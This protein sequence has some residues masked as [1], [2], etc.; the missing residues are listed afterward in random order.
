LFI[1]LTGTPIVIKPVYIILLTIF[2][3]HVL[4]KLYFIDKTNNKK[5]Y[6]VLVSDKL[7][8][9]LTYVEDKNIVE[10]L[11]QGP[12]D[13]TA[14]VEPE[15]E[16]PIPTPEP[17]PEPEPPKPS[18]GI[19]VDENGIKMLHP[20]T[21][22]FVEITEGKDHRNGQRY[23]KNHSFGNYMWIGYVKLGAGQDVMEHKTDG[24]NHGGCNEQEDAGKKFPVQDCCWVEVNISLTD[25][26]GYK[27][28]Q[29][30]ISS[31]HPH[32]K[33]Y[34]APK[35]SIGKKIFKIK[36]E[37][38]LG[39]AA[40]AWQEGEFRHLQG[41]VDTNPFDK[42]GKPLNNWEMGIDLVDT[43]FITTPDLAKRDVQHI[44]KTHV[45]DKNKGMVGLESEVRMNNA[46]N[47]DTEIKFARV[48]ELVHP[49][50][51]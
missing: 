5:Y 32:P 8:G 47:H 43:G 16:P 22:K 11:W 9:A 12:I 26:K 15:P 14:S 33:N 4:L 48:Y 3:L 38:W 46:T 29:F 23:S 25:R 37:Q 40:C 28:G 27:P 2:R 1:I 44:A 24:P 45:K 36:P 6:L 49:V 18:E 7:E 31:E 20:V 51:A 17:E 35:E 21:G 39:Y 19:D 41:W 30:Y 42:N 50:T 13:L 10:T 34:D